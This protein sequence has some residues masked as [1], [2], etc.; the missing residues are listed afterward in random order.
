MASLECS[1]CGKQ[2]KTRQL[3]LLKQHERKHTGELP[4][5]CQLTGCQKRFSRKDSMLVHYNKHL[6]EYICP[7]EE[8][9]MVF[10]T[11]M[12]LFRHSRFHNNICNICGTYFETRPFLR[13]HRLRVHGESEFKC[14]EG[15]DISIPLSPIH[16]SQWRLRVC[17]TM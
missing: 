16:R 12:D 6:M 1:Y 14:T 11:S 7:V 9:K 2:Y 8:C 13:T 4:F 17:Y 10:G 3:S 15:I 5:A